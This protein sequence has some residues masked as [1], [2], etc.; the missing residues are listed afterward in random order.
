MAEVD[1]FDAIL[2]ACDLTPRRACLGFAEVM[3]ELA[4]IAIRH[5]G[6]QP[7]AIIRGVQLDLGD[8]W[9]VF[10]GGVFIA[11]DG[12][13]ELVKIDLLVE[14]QIGLGA[15]ACVR[16]ARVEDAFAVRRPCRAAAAGRPRGGYVLDRADK[17][18][19]RLPDKKLIL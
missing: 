14:V 17:R 5:G 12:C 1:L 13:A 3:R 7:A 6:E 10:S 11:A 2:M 8:A 16:I 19:Q 9:K 15:L 18:L 4:A